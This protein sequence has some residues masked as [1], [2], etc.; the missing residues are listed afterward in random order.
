[1]GL[2]F[3]AEVVPSLSLSVVNYKMQYKNNRGLYPL[4]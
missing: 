3:K 2:D 4:V 1:M